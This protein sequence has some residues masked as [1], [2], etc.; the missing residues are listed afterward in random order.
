MTALVATKP[1]TEAD[2]SRRMKM[3]DPI[4]SILRDSI[5]SVGLR[6]SDPHGD[7]TDGT[8]MRIM[9][10]AID[11]LRRLRS[12]CA[13]E[14]A[15]DGTTNETVRDSACSGTGTAQNDADLG[16]SGA[17]ANENGAGLSH[18]KIVDGEGDQSSLLQSLACAAISCVESLR[19]LVQLVNQS[20]KGS[21]KTSGQAWKALES[22]VSSTFGE[23]A[24]G[25][26]PESGDISRALALLA[27]GI[28][29]SVDSADSSTTRMIASAVLPGNPK[30][31]SLQ[32][33]TKYQKQ[34]ESKT[35]TTGEGHF[36]E[37]QDTQ[38]IVHS[39]SRAALLGLLRLAADAMKDR[40]DGTS[41]DL[42]VVAKL[43]SGFSVGALGRTLNVGGGHE[44]LA[45]AVAGVV[46]VVFGRS[47]RPDDGDA[48]D[49]EYGDG[50][51]LLSKDLI[52]PTFSLVAAARPW[53]R[54]QVEKLVTC[55]AELDLWYSAELLCDAGT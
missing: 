46:D 29:L 16:D 32:K 52:A 10:G 33:G 54:V 47:V 31:E 8:G 48:D 49:C 25:G 28:A 23:T 43:E 37:V 40:S 36:E 13:D 9:P 12:T 24:I 55:A 27:V 42:Q 50:G 45:E 44:E 7:G 1:T 11:L 2:G 5:Q 34:E 30:V 22:V 39:M 17:A 6:N 38:T 53:D 4:A 20:R 3:V 19:Q 18:S 26:S 15:D 21:R 41:V 51:E 14:S 35:M